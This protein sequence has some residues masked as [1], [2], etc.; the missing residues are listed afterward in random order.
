VILSSSILARKLS[1]LA[2]NSEVDGGGGQA[3]TPNS[4]QSISIK[5]CLRDLETILARIL[6]FTW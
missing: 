1:I 5:R 4:G 2:S 3:A 6:S